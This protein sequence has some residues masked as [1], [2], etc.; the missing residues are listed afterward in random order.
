[1]NT[2][3]AERSSKALRRV[4]LGYLVLILLMAES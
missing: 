4:L 2:E 1:M 3:N